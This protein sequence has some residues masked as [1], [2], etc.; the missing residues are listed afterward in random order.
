MRRSA[1][2][3]GPILALG[4]VLTLS[5]PASASGLIPRIQIEMM[6]LQDSLDRYR[7][8]RGTYPVTDEHGTWIEKLQRDG[9]FDGERFG[10]RIIGEQ[11]RS[12]AFGAY[13]YSPPE[14][15]AAPAA[16]PAQRPLLHWTGKNGIDDH[17]AGDDVTLF[18]SVNSGYYWKRHWPWV[19][20]LFGLFSIA[21]LILLIWLA[22]ARRLGW[23]RLVFLSVV[24]WTIAYIAIRPLLYAPFRVGAATAHPGAGDWVLACWLLVAL[25][26]IQVARHRHQRERAR[27]GRCPTCHYDLQGLNDHHPCPECGTP[28]RPSQPKSHAQGRRG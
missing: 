22:R 28:P 24:F 16:D 21:Y 7:A 19:R 23:V 25:G 11:I 2:A 26:L 1:Q 20:P 10:N 9:Y 18:R 12:V 17:R 27:K 5:A 8:E 14:D 6:D 4:C 3:P 13:V 15:P